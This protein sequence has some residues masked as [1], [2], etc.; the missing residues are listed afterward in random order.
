MYTIATGWRQRLRLMPPGRHRAAALAYIIRRRSSGFAISCHPRLPPRSASASA[1]IQI[2]WKAP[3]SATASGAQC[4]Q[5]ASRR[6][7]HACDMRD[8]SCAAS[9]CV[10]F[11]GAGKPPGRSTQS[12][13]TG[14]P[15]PRRSP[16]HSSSCSPLRR[17]RMNSPSCVMQILTIDFK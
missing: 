8:C 7:K 3:T 9:P 17:W 16:R 15:V 11:A 14:S 12:S 10:A 13:R 2:R 4:T 6:R 5:S 1:L